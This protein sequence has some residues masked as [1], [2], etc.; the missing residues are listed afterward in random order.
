MKPDR[1][2][3]ILRELYSDGSCDEEFPCGITEK[4]RISKARSELAKLIREEKLTSDFQDDDAHYN[5]GIE[6][7]AKLM[8]G[9]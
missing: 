6:T 2:G 3:E 5:H 7:I 4:D 1:V 9:E 8:E